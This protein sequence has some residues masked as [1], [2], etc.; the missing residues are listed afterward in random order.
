[1]LQADSEDMYQ[2]WVQA[3]QQGIGAAIQ[4]TSD[5][6]HNTTNQ[7]NTGGTGNNNNMNNKD[8]VKNK[9]TR[10]V[11]F[12]LLKLCWLELITVILTI[13]VPFHSSRQSL[14]T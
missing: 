6:M 9:K 4:H 13:F 12:Y 1:M 3:L 5:D 2:A 8:G 11:L 14:L 10:L 7:N